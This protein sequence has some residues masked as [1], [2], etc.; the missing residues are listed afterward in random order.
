MILRCLVF[1]SVALWLSILS[2]ARVKA[3]VN[4]NAHQTILAIYQK[5]HQGYFRRNVTAELSGVSPAFVSTT[6]LG[7]KFDYAYERKHMQSAFDDATPS[8]WAN[9]RTSWVIEGFAVNG[10]EAKVRVRS[11]SVVKSISSK[12]KRPYYQSVDEV[13][14]NIWVK[15][16]HGWFETQEQFLSSQHTY[17]LAR[18]N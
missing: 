16:S 9:Q 2:V 4:A 18:I 14:V 6:V 7:T 8:E 1:T 13:V 3:D 15:T 10:N 12:A 17:S 11:H 5:Q